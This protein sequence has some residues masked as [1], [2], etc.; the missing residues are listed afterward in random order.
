STGTWEFA[1]FVSQFMGSGNINVRPFLTCDFNRSLFMG[2]IGVRV[3][4]TNGEGFNSQ[5][6]RCCNRCSHVIFNQ[7]RQDFTFIAH[8][9][10]YFQAQLAWDKRLWLGE[11]EIVEIRSVGS[12]NF[13]H[14]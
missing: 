4:E 10:R 1:P 13:E 6:S 8:P 7:R 9:F 11:Q 2:W 3:Q 14:V 12:L 5:A